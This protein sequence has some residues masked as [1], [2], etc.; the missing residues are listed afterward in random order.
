MSWKSGAGAGFIMVPASGLWPTYLGD[1]PWPKPCL[2][3]PEDRQGISFPKALFLC[4][5]M[6]AK[7]GIV[8]KET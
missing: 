6:T 1:A 4:G 5:G 7:P 3:C 2:L 8:L